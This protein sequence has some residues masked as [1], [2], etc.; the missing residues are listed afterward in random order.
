MNG[1]SQNSGVLSIGHFLEY[2]RLK[3]FNVG[4]VHYFRVQQV[5]DKLGE[6]LRADQPEYLKSLL[7]PIF[8]TSK[9]EQRRFSK[10]FDD[11][12]EYCEKSV[13]IRKP[14]ENGEKQGPDR[15]R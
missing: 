3:K 7:C 15:S 14:R 2:L 5:F 9:E 13:G 10:V 12:I 4:F 6:D 8:A 11:Y 1:P